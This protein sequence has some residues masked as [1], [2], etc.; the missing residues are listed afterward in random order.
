MD[1]RKKEA[2]E[3]VCDGGAEGSRGARGYRVSSG[4]RGQI[5]WVEIGVVVVRRRGGWMP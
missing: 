1:D 2:R 4:T 3:R 5:K